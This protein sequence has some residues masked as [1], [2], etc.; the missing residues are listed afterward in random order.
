V[1]TGSERIRRPVVARARPSVRRAAE[2]LR[3]RHWPRAAPSKRSDNLTP[4]VPPRG[5]ARHPS[6]PTDVFRRAG[7]PG[8][9]RS[10]RQTGNSQSELLT[11]WRLR[12][13]VA[14]AASRLAERH[15]A[16]AAARREVARPLWLWPR[17][18]A[19]QLRAAALCCANIFCHENCSFL[20]I[21]EP[22]TGTLHATQGQSCRSLEAVT[23]EVWKFRRFNETCRWESL[24]QYRCG[25]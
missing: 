19:A 17:A 24:Y 13:E 18:L 4:R 12:S 10:A 14:L 15:R 21:R 8:P 11:C 1:K 23:E 5:R 16:G 22:P 3:L 2:Q 9:V 6:K 25:R 20:C 7:A